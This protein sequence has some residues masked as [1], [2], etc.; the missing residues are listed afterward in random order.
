[1]NLK[2][3]ITMASG[4]DL[5]S[6]ENAKKRLLPVAD[7]HL[8][9]NCDFI[10]AASIKAENRPKALKSTKKCKKNEK[11]SKND[12]Q[13]A[14]KQLYLEHVLNNIRENAENYRCS[15][16]GIGRRVW[17]R[18]IWCKP[19]GFKSPLEYHLFLYGVQPT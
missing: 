3:S 10:C 11:K 17:L 6:T 13:N 15:G 5:Q 18:S 4:I 9:K 8:N 1:M 16:G 2:H 7:V 12:L 19:W 14:K